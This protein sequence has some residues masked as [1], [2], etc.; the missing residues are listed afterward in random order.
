MTKWT[1]K[2][3]GVDFSDVVHKY[4]YRTDLIPVFSRCVTTLDHVAHERL[5]RRRGELTITTN[6][7][8]AERAAAFYAALSALPASITYHSFQLGTD[9]TQTMKT[10]GLPLSYVMGTSTEDWLDKLQITF[11][12]R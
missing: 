10:S 1:F 11:T 12:E 8:P 9:V 6:P 3:N 4:G 7:V 2:I 5:V